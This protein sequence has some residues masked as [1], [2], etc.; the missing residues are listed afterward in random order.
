MFSRLTECG[1]RCEKNKIIPLA[2][3]SAILLPKATRIGLLVNPADA[4]ATV[5]QLKEIDAA[6]RAMAG[7]LTR[8][9]RISLAVGVLPMCASRVHSLGSK[10]GLFSS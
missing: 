9:F 8:S 7:E 5:P 3:M 10:T 4:A 2:A 1:R 6:A